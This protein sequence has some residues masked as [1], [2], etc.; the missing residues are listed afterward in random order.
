MAKPPKPPKPPKPTKPTKPAK[1]FQ[2]LDEEGGAVLDAN[3]QPVMVVILK[4]LARGMVEVREVVSGNTHE[5]KRDRLYRPE[6]GEDPEPAPA[7]PPA[8]ADAAPEGEGV[9]AD[10][11]PAQ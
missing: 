6:E 9:A 2:L 10:E 5:L 1:E 8:A 4:K 11:P 3:G 7:P